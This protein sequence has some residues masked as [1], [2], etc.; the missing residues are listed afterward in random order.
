VA[1]N[2][3]SGI[4]GSGSLYL[5]DSEVGTHGGADEPGT[6]AIIVQGKADIQGSTIADNSTGIVVYAD[7]A[8]GTGGL[9][10]VNST[11]AGNGAYGGEAILIETGVDARIVNSTLTGNNGNRDDGVPGLGIVI[12]PGATLA[13]VNSIVDDSIDG[14]LTSNGANI[15]RD[16]SVDG[17]VAGDRL[18]V[19][20]TEIFRDTATAATADGPVPVGVLADNGG[21]TRTAALL[22]SAANP[23]LNGADPATAPETDQRG[24]SRTRRPI[25]AP[26]SSAPP[27]HRP[28]IPT[29]IPT[30]TSILWR[31]CLRSRRSSRSTRR[32]SMACRRRR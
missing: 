28:S 8:S 15:F 2:G 13:L 16:A 12:V 26:S 32:W 21:P 5:V 3:D 31:R 6:S 4:G 14:T 20:A 23:A 1:G 11:L 27:R 29:R 18:G 24:L 22:D 7:P 30:P 17:A 9:T 10:L 19:S 25:S